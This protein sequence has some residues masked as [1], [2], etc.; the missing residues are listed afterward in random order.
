M[1]SLLHNIFDERQKDPHLGL[2]RPLRESPAVNLMLQSSY[3][4][5]W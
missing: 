1:F 3:L 5:G 4:Q 2:R